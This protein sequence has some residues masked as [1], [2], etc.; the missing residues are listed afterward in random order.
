MR[1]ISPNFIFS[2][3]YSEIYED[4]IT[5]EI[6][7]ILRRNQRRYKKAFDTVYNDNDS[8]VLLRQA[9]LMVVGEQSSGKT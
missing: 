8:L 6:N 4:K 5:A 9:K 1:N 3:L 2:C 7:E